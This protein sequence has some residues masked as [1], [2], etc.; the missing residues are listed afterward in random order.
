M[1]VITLTLE[2][3]D[4]DNRVACLAARQL[5]RSYWHVITLFSGSAPIMQVWPN[6]FISEIADEAER[7]RL[8]NHFLTFQERK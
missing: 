7:E 1:G 8:V 5:A 3:F 2:E 4:N 6:G